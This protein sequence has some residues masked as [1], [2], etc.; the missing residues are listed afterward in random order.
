MKN[1]VKTRLRNHYRIYK[2]RK[3]S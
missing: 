1:S 2:R 3:L